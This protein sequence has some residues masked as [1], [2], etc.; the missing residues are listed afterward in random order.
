MA[1]TAQGYIFFESRL[2]DALLASLIKDYKEQSPSTLGRTTLLKLCYFAKA[3]GVP[4][5]FLFEICHYGPYSQEVLDRTRNLVLEGIIEDQSV[6][7]GQSNFV[8][9]PNLEKFLNHFRDLTREY[10]PSVRN[11]AGLI[12]RLDTLDTEL[13]S[14]IHFIYSSRRDWYK[15]SPSKE[16]VVQFMLKISADQDS[17]ERVEKAYAILNEAALLA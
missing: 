10:E 3:S 15:K 13:I 17:R 1:A 14:K 4:L 5:P 9:G 11:I 2:A 16:S 6:V 12:S 8:P 7:S